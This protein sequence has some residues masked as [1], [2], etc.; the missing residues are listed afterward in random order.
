MKPPVMKPLLLAAAIAAL[1][2]PAAVPDA[3]KAYVKHNAGMQFPYEGPEIRIGHT[4]PD[5]DQDWLGIPNYPQYRWQNLAGQLVV[6][7]HQTRKVVA[8]Y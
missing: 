2:A 3:V 6:I 1:S 4:V 5:A 7:D 8:I